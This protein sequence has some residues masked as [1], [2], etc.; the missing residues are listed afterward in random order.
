MKPVFF[1]QQTPDMPTLK[2]KMK[3]SECSIFSQAYVHCT[4]F[5]VHD[6]GGNTVSQFRSPP[7]PAEVFQ[8]VNWRAK[9]SSSQSRTSRDMR[10]QDPGSFR[11]HLSYNLEPFECE[12]THTHTCTLHSTYSYVYLSLII[13]RFPLEIIS[14]ISEPANSLLNGHL[15]FP[16]QP[17]AVCS[18]HRLYR[19]FKCVRFRERE[20]T[21]WMKLNI[22]RYCICIIKIL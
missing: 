18:V 7:A 6:P 3:T 9:P 14:I 22:C 1:T 20:K 17:F 5:G 8:N 19:T 11:V 13:P 10:D 15:P 4:R 16:F 2:Q 12:H 21:G